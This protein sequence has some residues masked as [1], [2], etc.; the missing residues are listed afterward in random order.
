MKK[1]YLLLV[2]LMCSMSVFSQAYLSVSS[3]KL[4]IGNATGS[5]RYIPTNQVQWVTSVSAGTVALKDLAGNSISGFT[6][7]ISYTSYRINGTTPASL[8]ALVS[9]LQTNVSS[10]SGGG[11]GGA[12]TITNPLLQSISDFTATTSYAAFPSA[13]CQFIEIQNNRVGAVDIQYYKSGDATN[14]TVIPAGSTKRI[15]VANPNT[16]FVAAS[17]GIRNI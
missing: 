13:T 14:Y 6:G 16:I 15:Y 11:G 1:I 10:T 4:L 3:G 5:G 12:V 2:G 8:T 7:D 9:W 17:A